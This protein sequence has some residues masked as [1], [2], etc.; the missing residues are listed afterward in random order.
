MQRSEGAPCQRA[1][2]SALRR[3][4]RD[5]PALEQCVNRHGCDDR[6][7]AHSDDLTCIDAAPKG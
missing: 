2:E 6:I 1:T 7:Q 5:A 4:R 3:L